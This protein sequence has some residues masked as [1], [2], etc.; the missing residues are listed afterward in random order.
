MGAAGGKKMKGRERINIKK[1]VL[2]LE[3]IKLISG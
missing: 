1:V 2:I 3:K